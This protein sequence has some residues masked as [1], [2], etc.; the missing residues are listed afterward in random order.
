MPN[1]RSWHK[2]VHQ[3]RFTPQLYQT[4]S[5][6]IQPVEAIAVVQT[7]FI[8]IYPFRDELTV[9][10]QALSA[11]AVFSYCFYRPTLWVAL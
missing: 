2:A 9:H 8:L 3:I 7:G 10:Y 11:S 5:E 6:L 1:A 4:Q